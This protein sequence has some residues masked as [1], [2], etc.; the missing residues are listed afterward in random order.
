M[1][2]RIFAKAAFFSIPK[3]FLSTSVYNQMAAGEQLLK[4]NQNY[5]KVQQQTSASGGMTEP[6]LMNSELS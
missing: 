3:I 1:Q 6:L 4:R 2:R 5:T